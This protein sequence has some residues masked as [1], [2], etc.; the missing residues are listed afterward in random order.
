[1][2]QSSLHC[3]AFLPCRSIRQLCIAETPGPDGDPKQSSAG[4]EDLQCI[5]A[6][7]PSLHVC[8]SVYASYTGRSTHTLMLQGARAPLCST[9][10]SP[11]T[12]LLSHCF[13]AQ[14]ISSVSK[15]QQR[16]G[17]GVLHLEALQPDRNRPREPSAP[18]PPAMRRAPAR[19]LLVAM[20]TA[21]HWGLDG[22]F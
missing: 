15:N 19:R 6:R 16:R 2:L 13:S 7:E 8:I 22:G 10:S 17:R 12:A 4:C 9:L 18:W 14:H 3:L 21:L 11:R 1:M 5:P 20:I